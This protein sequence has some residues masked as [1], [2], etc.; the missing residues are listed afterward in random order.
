MR[1][2][3]FVGFLA[4]L[5]TTPVAAQDR[6]AFVV[7]M[8]F[9]GD[10][11][12]FFNPWRLGETLLGA[13]GRLF[14]DVDLNER[15]TLRG[16]LFGNH[17]FG[18]DRN[19]ETVRPV[20]A[21]HIK[22]DFNRFVIGSI[23]SG[24][25]PLGAKPEQLGPHGLLPPLQRESLAFIRPDEAGLQWTFHTN[26]F[27]QEAWINWQRLN[28]RLNRELFDT[29]IRGQ[30]SVDQNLPISL[31]YQFHLVH[32]GG[33]QFDSGPVADSWGGGPGLIVELPTG[34]F[35]R[36]TAEIHGLISRDVPNRLQ[37]SNART[38]FGLFTR[39]MAEKA[40]WRMHAIAWRARNFVKREGD[41]NYGSL[42]TNE[43]I[44]SLRHYFETGV[45]RAFYPAE[46]VGLELSARLHRVDTHHD[47][48]FRILAKVDFDIPLKIPQRQPRTQTSENISG[49]SSQSSL[50]Q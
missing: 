2:I 6:A 48:S 8:T 38:G 43:R 14:L 46:E 50:L 10:N 5:S 29:G 20:L 17:R 22:N 40:G 30:L 11:T 24:T 12:E 27:D 9:Y 37:M 28:T 3:A 42:H 44:T 13:E 36:Q 39:Y 41:E 49:G 32:Q 4:L 45:T 21:L 1:F 15:V 19:F 33:Q 47:Y 34:V 35:D 18:D 25:Q 7:D 16:G 23:E 31:S 26:R